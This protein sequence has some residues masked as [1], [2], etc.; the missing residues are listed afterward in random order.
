MMTKRSRIVL[1]DNF[2]IKDGH[3]TFNKK[4]TDPMNAKQFANEMI[5]H[6]YRDG[7]SHYRE[8]LNKLDI[9]NK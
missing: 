9:I 8:C 7:W 1:E 4:W 2:S 6:T 5:K 3:P